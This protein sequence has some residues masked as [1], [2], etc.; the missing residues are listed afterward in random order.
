MSAEHLA[1]CADQAG[2]N[3]VLE[4]EQI[5]GRMRVD[6]VLVDLDDSWLAAEEGAGDLDLFAVIANDDS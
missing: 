4:D 5:P 3:G 6:V 2:G 1:E